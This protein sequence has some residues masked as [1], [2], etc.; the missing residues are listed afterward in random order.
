M[1]L[2]LASSSERNDLYVALR[3]TFLHKGN[4]V[5]LHNDCFRGSR[6]SAKLGRRSSEQSYHCESTKFKCTVERMS[7]RAA[8]FVLPF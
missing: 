2:A 6:A 3:K 8:M 1:S 5:E 4:C 7:D